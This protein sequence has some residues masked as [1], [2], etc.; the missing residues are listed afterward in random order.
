[1]TKLLQ[2]VSVG[3]A[4][5]ALLGASFA[6]S[7][8]AADVTIDGNGAGSTNVVTVKSTCDSSV[9]QT[10]STNVSTMAHVTADTGGNSVTGNTGGSSSIDTGD[11]TA[12]VSVSVEGGSNSA[13]P[14][15]CCACLQG[16]GNDVTIS[17]NGVNT[18]NVVSDTNKQK[19]KVTQKNKT[20]VMTYASVKAK[21]GYNK[22][23][24]NTGSGSDLTTGDASAGLEVTVTSSS[25]STP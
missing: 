24:N 21:T 15:S 25:N 10:N 14:A 13:E 1:M 4:T 19:T 6:T 20:F 17:G 7:A 8:F 2:K 23:K 9:Y 12:G 18:T 5:A 16:V 3:V 22:L 11:A